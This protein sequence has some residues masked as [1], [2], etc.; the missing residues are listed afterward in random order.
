MCEY[1]FR[2]RECSVLV[3]II[4]IDTSGGSERKPFRGKIIIIF[5]RRHLYW[6]LL[7]RPGKAIRKNARALL[8]RVLTTLR[9]LGGVAPRSLYRYL[10]ISPVIN[11]FRSTGRYMVSVCHC[12]RC[13]IERC[14]IHMNVRVREYMA[15]VKIPF[16]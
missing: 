16:I 8:R 15:A 9:G 5:H 13:F 3:Y 6:R 14:L 12:F 4:I 7:P 2:Y 1:R 10:R 11:Q